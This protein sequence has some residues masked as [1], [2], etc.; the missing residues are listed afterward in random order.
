M[1][2][3]VRNDLQVQL[4]PP[5][6]MMKSMWSD[7]HL[8]D[9]SVSSRTQPP[10]F[11]HQHHPAAHAVP[12]R[13]VHWVSMYKLM[14]HTVCVCVGGGGSPTATV[15]MSSRASLPRGVETC[16]LTP[17]RASSWVSAAAGNCLGVLDWIW[18]YKPTG[19]VHCIGWP[20]LSLRT[21]LLFVSLAS[22]PIPL[23]LC[24][25][26]FPQRGNCSHCHH[27]LSCGCLLLCLQLSSAV[28]GLCQ[29]ACQVC[30]VCPCATQPSP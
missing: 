3:S 2:C 27:C 28:L 1:G 6:F 4:D 12:M 21:A 24:V 22:M 19:H 13:R 26:N 23:T 16:L 30:S 5:G 17:C 8:H 20:P 14:S 29:P 10:L 7:V 15:F 25:F 18:T 9:C 11:V